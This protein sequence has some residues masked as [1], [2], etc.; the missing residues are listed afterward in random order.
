MGKQSFQEA[1]VIKLSQSITYWNYTIMDPNETYNIMDQALYLVNNKKQVHI[2]IPKDILSSSITNNRGI[3][4]N[5]KL[6]KPNIESLHFKIKYVANIINNS[7]KPV[8]LI[9]KGCNNACDE[10]YKVSKK[11]N[12]PV[13]TTLHGLG[14]FDESDELSLKMIGMHGSER[15]NQSIQTADC[16]ICVGA[17]FDDRTTGNIKK[18]A[19]YARHIIYVNSDSTCFG[20]ILKDTYNVHAYAIEFLDLL[21]MYIKPKSNEWLLSLNNYP[22]NFPY[23]YSGLK[24]QHILEILND[25]LEKLNIKK[26]VFFTTGV[27]N[28]QM[29]AAQFITHKYPNRFITSGSLGTMGSCNSMAIGTK[30]ANPDKII[31]AIDGDQSFNMLNDLKMIMNYNIG[32][33]IILMNDSKQSMVNIWEKLFFNE[34]ITATESINPNYENIA[35]AYNIKCINIDKTMDMNKITCLIKDFINYDNNKPIILNCIIDSDYCFPLV[36]PNAALNEMITFN[37]F[38]KSNDNISPE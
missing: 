22:I 25:V 12:I 20:K 23:D 34:N 30:I 17:R 27:G 33:K 32:I 13:T 35:E 26:N 8:F 4:L 28:H 7:I 24:Q 36:P 21:F 11:A 38:T 2:N 6:D 3:T 18:Y 16:I 9:G 1:P 29:F 5:K 14:I 10:L 19:P 31:I 15:A 37:N